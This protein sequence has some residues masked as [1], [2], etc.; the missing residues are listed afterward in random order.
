MNSFLRVVAVAGFV[1]VSVALSH[2]Q[3][4]FE[5]ERAMTREERIRAHQAKID[6]II[7]ENR[8]RQ[9][10]AAKSAG[11]ASANPTPAT[12]PFPMQQSQP[13]PAPAGG[14]P[15]PPPSAAASAP[16]QPI[17]P[18]PVQP[19]VPAAPGAPMPVAAAAPAAPKAARS[20]ARSM[21]YFR[22]FDTVVNLG[23]TFATEVFADTRDGSADELS[24]YIQYPK[25]VVNPL[26]IDHSDIDSYVKGEIE[27]SA[28][29]KAG[30]LY[31]RIPLQDAHK[32]P[33]RKIASIIWEALEPASVSHIKFLF[34]KKKTSG[35]FLKGANVLGTSAAAQDGVLNA[36][37]MVRER[38]T[39]PVVQ[40]NDSGLVITSS[41]LVPPSPTMAVWLR[42]SRQNVKQDE[43]FSVD[44]VLDNPQNAPLDHLRLL[45]QFNPSD[46]EVVDWDR[47]N[48]IRE[49]AN[50][51]DGFAHESFPFDFHKSNC[52]DNKRGV[53]VYEEASQSQPIRASGVV[54][55]AKFRAKRPI[56]RTGIVLL[57]NDPGEKPTTDVSYMG[58]SMLAEK[59]AQAGPLTN[60]E[61]TVASAP[62]R[63]ANGKPAQPATA[64]RRGPSLLGR[65]TQ[66]R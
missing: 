65:N 40:K 20:E 9:E 44:V 5:K 32:F 62:P 23:E 10:E 56:E 47:G 54:A 52:A 55:R 1:L 4:E 22:P 28:D 64:S 24:F 39:K 15:V 25:T 42:P 33:G 59:P 58:V 29:P 2:A 37:V 60:V 48:W 17:P 63:P 26:A 27:Y 3:E 45:L 30:E 66:T 51:G 38:R 21:L 6:K 50:I 49:G 31:V 13:S 53:I 35:I 12:P 8:K 18:G 41:R 36:T 19:Y 46:M 16:G 61:M 34:G 7:Q 57:V 43:I 14:P 11:A